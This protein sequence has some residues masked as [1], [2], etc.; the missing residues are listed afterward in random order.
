VIHF[1][2]N[3]RRNATEAERLLWSRLRRRQL[4]GFKFRRQH[5]IGSYVCD[6]ICLEAVVIVELDGSH[7]LDQ[8][9]YDLHHDAFLRR[10]GFRILRFW[11]VDVMAGIENVTETI[12]EALHRRDM[13]GRFD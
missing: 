2:R 12:F 8:A 10:R 13:D 11:N 4:G 9:P 1:A 3:L 7:H 6:F 5:Q